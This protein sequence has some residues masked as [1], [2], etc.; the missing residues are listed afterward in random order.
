[1]S[2]SSTFSF[3]SPDGAGLVG[4]W[5]PASQS[6]GVALIV[7]G[8]AEHAGR[9]AEV[10]GQLGDEHLDVLA[11]D[12]RG[13]GRSSGRRGHCHKFAEFL[14]DYDAAYEQAR[15]RADGK[16][17]VV[18]GHS[19]G[20]LIVL[21]AL[22]RGDKPR[23]LAAVVSSPFLGLKLR[24]SPVTRIAG[25]LASRVWPALAF[26]N[27]LVVEDLTT[28]PVKQDERRR[29]Q[30]CN[31]VATARWFTEATHAQGE[32]LAMAAQITTPTCWL[33]A[34]DDPIA[35]AAASRRLQQRLKAPSEFH[36]LAG[37]RHEVFNEAQRSVPFALMRTFIKHQ[38]A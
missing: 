5:Y 21:R 1:M 38:L 17:I 25:E 26:P 4:D 34:G 18:I 9:Y 8:Y 14:G 35:D 15:L 3:S 2:I 32:T 37:F 24:I 6:R 23:P 19:H 36:E 29:D 30:L 11:F 22:C 28:D 13:H 16:P 7:H 12:V 10:A 27:K 20:S 31:T 33:V